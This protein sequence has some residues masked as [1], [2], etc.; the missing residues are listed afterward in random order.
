[1]RG[2][3]QAA[4]LVQAGKIGDIGNCIQLVPPGDPVLLL[5]S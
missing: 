3:N 4:L 2:L 1:L 5:L